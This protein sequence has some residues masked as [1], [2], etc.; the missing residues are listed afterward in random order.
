MYSSVIKVTTTNNGPV[1][2]CI[3][4]IIPEEILLYSICHKFI[5]AKM[6]ILNLIIKEYLTN[7]SDVI[8]HSNKIKFKNHIT[9][10][11]WL[12]QGWGIQKLASGKSMYKFWQIK[13][14]VTS[15]FIYKNWRI[16]NKQNPERVEGRK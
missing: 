4:Y 10:G 8:H 3:H 12:M 7:L 2:S 9:L 5:N 1:T 6:H 16:N 14:F 15:P 11:T 13:I